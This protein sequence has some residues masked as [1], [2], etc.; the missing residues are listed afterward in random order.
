MILFFLVNQFLIDIFYEV[1]KKENVVLMLIGQGELESNIKEKVLTLNIKDKVFFLGKRND[2]FNYYNAMD[3]FVLPS[4]YEGLPVVGVESQANGLPCVFSN[5]VTDETKILD[6]T[7][8]VKDKLEDYVEAIINNLG[9]ERKNT[10]D[11]VKLAG[12]DIKTES[13]KLL[14]IYTSFIKTI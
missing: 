10:E 12:F 6:S 3:L 5:N 1:L 13:K 7:V 2:T 14:D 8:F 11:V 4:R 9:I